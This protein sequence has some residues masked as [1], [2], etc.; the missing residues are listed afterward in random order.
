[1][2]SVKEIVSFRKQSH[3]INRLNRNDMKKTAFIAF[4]RFGLRMGGMFV[5]FDRRSEE[6]PV[7]DEKKIGLGIN[8]ASF[9]FPG[10]LLPAN[11]T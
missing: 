7:G 8:V 4:G 1:M 3:A 10:R 11:R 9:P 6:P 5:R 2:V